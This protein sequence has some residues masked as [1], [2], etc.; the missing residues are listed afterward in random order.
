MAVQPPPK[1]EKDL[2]V[3]IRQ[4]NSELE[5]PVPSDPPITAPRGHGTISN[6]RRQL[7]S[8]PHPQDL[9][10][11]AIVVTFEIIDVPG[12]SAPLFVATV[13]G[14]PEGVNGQQVL[15]DFFTARD[16]KKSALIVKD[17]S[18]GAPALTSIDECAHEGCDFGRGHNDGVHES[19]ES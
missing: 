13:V 12:L 15:D 8:R 2:E 10:V 4:H 11:P 9:Y 17:I 18:K 14:A 6:A 5:A 19:K 1:T 7:V 3:A 16:L